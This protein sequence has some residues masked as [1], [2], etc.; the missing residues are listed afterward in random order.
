MSIYT[1]FNHEPTALGTRYRVIIPLSHRVGP[2]A[3]KAIGHLLRD[4]IE[5]ARWFRFNSAKGASASTRYHGLDPSKDNATSIFYLPCRRAGHEA[6]HWIEHHDGEPMDVVEWLGRDMLR[7]I[8]DDQIIRPP[9]PKARETNT[10]DRLLSASGRDAA[11]GRYLALPGGTQDYGLNQLAWS[12]AGMGIG[13]E[14]IRD[15]LDDCARQSNS[16]Q[17][18]TAQMG[19]I[20]KHLARRR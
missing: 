9:M 14:E 1:S 5:Q 7:V 12:L 6:D 15:V 8:P 16:P 2:N 4:H 20:M 3:Y 13:M 19:R 11:I 17:D 10:I 18:R